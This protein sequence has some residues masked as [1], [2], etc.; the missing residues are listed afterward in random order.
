MRQ[1]CDQNWSLSSGQ[2]TL[3]YINFNNFDKYYREILIKMINWI[4]LQY[5]KYI[6]VWK[7]C[8]Y[9]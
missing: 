3:Q 2:I 6:K 8:F 5:E 7:V 9:S 4:K 1:F